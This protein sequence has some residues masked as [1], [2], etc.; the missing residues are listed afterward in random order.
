MV[1]V[2]CSGKLHAFNL[3]EQLEKQ[4]AL[5]AFFTSFSWQKNTLLRRFGGREDKEEIP[6]R[7]IHTA[8]PLAIGM[9]L[10]QDD[11]LWNDLFDRWVALQMGRQAGSRA[12][13]GWSGM[14]LRAI[15]AAKRLGM[16][17]VVVRGSAH[18]Q[19]QD[20]ILQEEYRK[21]GKPF[22]IDP[23]TV[24]KELLEYEEADFIDIPST[25]ARQSFLEKGIPDHKLVMNPYGFSSYFHRVEPAGDKKEDVLRILYLGNLTIQKGVIYLFEALRQLSIPEKNF[26]AWFI[27]KVDD[28]IKPSVE[29][30][31]RP[32]WKFFGHVNHYELPKLISACDLAVQPSLQDG[33]GM[34]ILQTLSCGVPVIA[35][36]NTGGPDAIEEGKNGF[37]V[38]IRNPEAIAARIQLLRDDPS[39]L[40]NMK[41]A[42]AGIGEQ[43]WTWEHYG[44]RYV[45]FI[46]KQFSHD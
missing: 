16:K 11:Y 27:G 20:S 44:A 4:G 39:L 30:Y 13:I 9:K 17:S 21:F 2:S 5:N 18:I 19:L 29:K 37:I 28:E 26:E 45:D 42:A 36:T 31:A 6:V 41:A 8:L 12:F 38:P 34:V 35:T 24:E 10:H 7:K 46:R 23:R 40:E 15:R 43:Q 33:F 22:R 25:F 32:N 1:T 3:A 14:S